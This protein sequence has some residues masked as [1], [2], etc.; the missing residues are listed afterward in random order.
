MIVAI[1]SAVACLVAS[2]SASAAPFADGSFETPAAPAGNFTDIAAPGAIGP[3]TV[4]AGSVDLIGAGYWQAADGVQSVDLD[5][6]TAGT[7]CQTYDAS[8]PGNGAATFQL[9]H[10]FAGTASATVQV[11]ANGV[12]VGTFTH[13]AAGTTGANMMY[14]PHTVSF[15]VTGPTTTL[16]FVSLTPG[17]FGPVIDAVALSGPAPGPA[18]LGITKSAAPTTVLHGQNVVY[19]LTVTNAGPNTATAPTI[20][21]TLPAGQSLVFADAACTTAGTPVVVT[22]P[23]ADLPSGSS[24]TIHLTASTGGIPAP[25]TGPLVQ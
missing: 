15:P 24:V 14:Q 3:W 6:T 12:P 18:N 20:T 17:G 9:S 4:T 7:I 2:A 5:G 23:T 21:D 22:C 11:T 25:L 8:S 1:G 19:T 13:N 10:N 16:C